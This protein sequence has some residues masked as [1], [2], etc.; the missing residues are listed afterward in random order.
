MALAL[1]M[2]AAY[3]ETPEIT[4]VDDFEITLINGEQF[5]LSE[6]QG[7]IVF[8]VMWATWCP[9]CVASMPALQQI[10][11]EY[12]DDVVILAVECGEPE[13]EVV[14][15]V[16]FYGYTFAFAAD[17][18]MDFIINRFPSSAIPYTAII[19]QNGALHTTHLG[20]GPNV[21]ERFFEIIDELLA[22]EI[23]E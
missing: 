22:T 5:V 2:G 23:T 16:N 21:H 1:T 12:P 14:D 9:S 17:E 13:A 7:K 6:Q 3:A 20:G 18:Q 10:A 19:D 8:V 4:P 11:D 15:F